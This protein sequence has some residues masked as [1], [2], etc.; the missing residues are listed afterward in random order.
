M[1]DVTYH[2]DRS[3]DHAYLVAAFGSMDTVLFRHREL[4]QP[5]A[6]KAPVDC[7]P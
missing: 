4:S 6:S 3:S 7:K 5:R 2:T 1:F